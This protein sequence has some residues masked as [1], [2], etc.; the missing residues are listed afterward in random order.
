MGVSHAL[1]ARILTALSSQPSELVLGLRS[2]ARPDV[3][4]NNREQ[5]QQPQHL[6]TPRTY[7]S[8]QS[9][10]PLW[11]TEACRRTT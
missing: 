11:T 10:T 2:T 8:N 6:T 1:L 3:K 4:N 9:S 7:S 5:Q